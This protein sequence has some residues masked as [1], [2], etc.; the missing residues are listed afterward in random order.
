M[1]NAEFNEEQHQRELAEYLDGLQFHLRAIR[2]GLSKMEAEMA[3]LQRRRAF[4]EY[5]LQR[6]E[7][8]TRPGRKARSRSGTDEPHPGRKGPA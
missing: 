5:H 3:K 6:L 7:F 8:E 2:H 1:S 4:M